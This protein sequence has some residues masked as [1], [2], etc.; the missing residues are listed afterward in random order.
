M[1]CREAKLLLAAQRN[2]DLA[3]SD[4]PVLQ[5]HLNHCPTCRAFEQRFQNLN[6][7]PRSSTP[8]PN[9]QGAHPA[10]PYVSISTERI[11][12]AVQRQQRISQQLEDI[13][14]KQQS[15]LARI[16]VVGI[17]LAA[18]IFFTLGS[19]PLL[20]LALMIVQPDLLVNTLPSLSGMID[21]LIVLGQYLQTGLT[22][23]THDSR[24]LAGVALIL[25]VM[26]GLWLRLMR[27]PRTM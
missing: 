7:L 5:D 10:Q 26:A 6:T 12:Q 1:R 2:G 9:T 23:T 17:P 3:Q 15:R 14:Q 25:V 19:I 27:H 18:I 20:V 21:I 16:R 13:H 11:M 4:V 22:L 24:L 8:G